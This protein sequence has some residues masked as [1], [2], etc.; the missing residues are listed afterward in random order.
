VVKTSLRQLKGEVSVHSKAGEGTTFTLYLPLTLSGERGLLVNVNNQLFVIPTHS[1]EH[2]W[3]ISI[4]DIIDI[5]GT[6]AVL[7]NKHPIPLRVLAVT[8]G[9][10]ESNAHLGQDLS[11]V[12]IREGK[13][14]VAFLV[15]AIVGEREIIIKPLNKPIKHLPCVSGGTLLERNQVVVVL[16]P[17]DLIRRSLNI[18]MA[19]R[20]NIDILEKVED[21][22]HILVA[23]DS[24]TTRTLEKNILESRN[25]KVT[26]A[27]NGKEAWDLLQKEKFSLLITDV[28]MPLMDG[29]VLTENVKNN[30]KLRNL[31]VIIVTSLGSEAEKA[32]GLDVGADAYIIKNEFE[33]GALLKIVSQLV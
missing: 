1:V 10:E 4:N 15:D 26:V 20:I 18:N 13:T 31:P 25:Y 12:V 28:N 3:M 19:Y 27:V 21:I 29:F 7:L 6:Q 30:E 24:I 5:E 11:I 17:A 33:S 16:N 2:V 23:D 32:R 8:L 9:L 14:V 22:V